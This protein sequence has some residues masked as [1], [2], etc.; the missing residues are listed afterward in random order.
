APYYA[1]DI[2]AKFP[3][4]TVEDAL[5]TLKFAAKQQQSCDEQAIA[6][7]GIKTDKAARC[8]PQIRQKQE[9]ASAIITDG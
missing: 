8:S 5:D 7:A 1:L 6:P 2:K 9:V 3:A 4:N